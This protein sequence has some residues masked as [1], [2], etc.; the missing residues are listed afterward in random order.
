MKPDAYD[1]LNHAMW[2]WQQ[3]AMMHNNASDIVK[4]YSG[5]QLNIETTDGL[6]KVTGVRYD[7]D[8]GIILT[9][10]DKT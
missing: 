9:T 8:H 2:L 4:Q 3:H 1:L 6:K 7:N 10:D 5:I